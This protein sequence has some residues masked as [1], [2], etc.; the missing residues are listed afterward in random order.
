VGVV[1]ARLAAEVPAVTVERP[2]LR[3]E[4]LVARPRLDQRAVDR[5]VL[6]GHPR[7]RAIDHAL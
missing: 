5:E 1:L 3:R 6:V 7:R 2:V 4:A